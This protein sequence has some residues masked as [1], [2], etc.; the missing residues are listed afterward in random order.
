MKYEI[1]I[2]WYPSK[3]QKAIEQTIGFC[4]DKDKAYR[5]VLYIAKVFSSYQTIDYNCIE[6]QKHKHSMIFGKIVIVEHLDKMQRKYG[7]FKKRLLVLG[8]SKT[9]SK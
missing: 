6:L 2:A 9:M 7:P 8:K 5:I 3:S 4:D 1:K